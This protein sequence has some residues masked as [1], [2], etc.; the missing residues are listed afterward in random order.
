[1]VWVRVR[2]ICGYDVK[3]NMSTAELIKLQIEKWQFTPTC[4]H[5]D[6]D[7]ITQYYKNIINVVPTFL[8][9]FL[10]TKLAVKEGYSLI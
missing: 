1:M 3:L 6:D 5:F 8:T 4:T 2:V 10:D 7:V 9:L